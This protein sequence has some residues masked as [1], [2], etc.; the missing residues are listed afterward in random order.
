M[1]QGANEDALQRSLQL[2]ALLYTE[3]EGKVRRAV[4]N[5]F[6]YALTQA[7]PMVH[8][9]RAKVLGQLPQ[10]LRHAYFAQ[11]HHTGGC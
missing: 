10:P 7:L 8:T 5:V 6:V 9:N 1:L 2:A 3:G 4:E 11:V